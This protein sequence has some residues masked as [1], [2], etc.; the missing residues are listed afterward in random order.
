[1]ASFANFKEKEKDRNQYK[2]EKG[3]HAVYSL[4]ASLRE[5]K[6]SQVFDQ[7]KKHTGYQIKGKTWTTTIYSLPQMPEFE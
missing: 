1:M 3:S 5:L 7:L 6:E 2:K 4:V